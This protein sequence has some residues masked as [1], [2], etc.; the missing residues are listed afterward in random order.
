MKE[1]QARELKPIELPQL[2]DSPL[3]S[4]LIPN[5]NYARYIGEAIESALNQT[6][7]HFEIIICDDGSSDNSCEVVE[8]HARKDPRIKLVRKQNGGVASALNAAYIESNGKIICLLDADDLWM[9][10]KLQKILEAFKSDPKSG[11]VIHNVIQIDSYGK[12]IK[13]TPMLSKLASGWM[14]PFALENGGFVEE[15]P[16]ASA[17]CIRREVAD[18]IFPINEEFVRNVDTV[19]SNFAVFVTVIV[20]V[21]EVLN[22]YRLHGTNLTGTSSITADL[23]EREMNVSKCIYQELKQFLTNF[24]G[25]KVA[26]KLTDL[27]FRLMYCHNRYLLTRLK[28]ALKAES[29]EAHRQLIAHPQFNWS[30]PER[31]LLQWGEYLPD[32]LFVAF[33]DQVYG[34]SQLKRI[35]RLIRRGAFAPASRK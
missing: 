29:R 9:P 14:A 2:L 31:W 18:L 15:L 11:F 33:F 3:V 35:A 4:V 32:A 19:V 28:D 6:Y 13:P 16:P 25:T 5:Y 34:R 24:Y 12:F 22:M 1:L 30:G 23:L 26:E 17:L 27:E 21:P 10:D 8:A 20:P 7:P